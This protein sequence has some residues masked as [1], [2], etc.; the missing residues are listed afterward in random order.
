[1]VFPLIGTAAYRERP[2]P[3]STRQP[4]LELSRRGRIER[5][6]ETG[7]VAVVAAAAHL[8]VAVEPGDGGTVAQRHRHLARLAARAEQIADR[9]EKLAPRPRPSS[10]T[11]GTGGPLGAGGAA[12][13]QGVPRLRRQRID[14]VQRLDDARAPPPS[15]IDAELA[16]HAPRRRRAAARCRDGR[17]RAHARSGRPRSPPRGSRGKRRPDGSA[18]RTRSRPCRRSRSRGRWAA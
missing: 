13:L 7:H 5:H 6:R 12:R 14:L 1:M 17:Y 2:Q 9:L 3:L 18:G 16:Q 10:P 15:S 11:P 4:A 8:A